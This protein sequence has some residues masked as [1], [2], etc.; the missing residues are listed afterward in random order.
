VRVGDRPL[1]FRGV[2]PVTE[3]ASS[4]LDNG[5]GQDCRGDRG[6]D[7]AFDKI[8]W[9]APSVTAESRAAVVADLGPALE[10]GFAAHPS[11]ARAVDQTAQGVAA[12]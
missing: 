4:L 3:F 1:V 8:G 6:H 7:L 12:E 11:A 10:V 9:A 2:Q 5:V